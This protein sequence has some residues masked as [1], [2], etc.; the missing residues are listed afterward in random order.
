MTIASDIEVS[1][2]DKLS[3]LIETAISEYGGLDRD[4]YYPNSEVWH[5]GVSIEGDGEYCGVCLAGAVIAGSLKVDHEV[6]YWDYDFS[7]HCDKLRALDF[8]RRGM[9][10]RAFSC[11][12]VVYSDFTD[13]QED[14]VLSIEREAQ[15]GEW[16]GVMNWLGWGDLDNALAHYKSVADRLRAVGL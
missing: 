16:S 3:D 2:P 15:A 4:I 14:L 1:L 5:Q 10:R 11:L 13:E 12:G 7:A 8:I 9:A 6:E